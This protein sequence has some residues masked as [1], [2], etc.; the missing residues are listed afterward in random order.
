MQ[1]IVAD[2]ECHYADVQLTGV[3]GGE[4]VFR[5]LLVHLHLNR[6]MGLREPRH[7]G[8][9]EERGDRRDRAG[10]QPAAFA[11]VA[12]GALGLVHGG[13][14]ALR[15]AQEFAA[16][17]GE[18]DLA[19]EPVEQAAADAVL[20]PF[21]TDHLFT[22][23]RLRDALALRGSGEAAGLGNGH[24]VTQLVEFHHEYRSVFGGGSFLPL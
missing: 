9:E 8:R 5:P 23:R 14:D 3:E 7:D 16:G 22:Q 24:E 20:L 1:V 11:R 19:A 4:E 2:G 21:E 13:E 6:G 15:A 10:P 17:V 12:D 18:D